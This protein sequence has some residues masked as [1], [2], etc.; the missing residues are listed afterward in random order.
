MEQNQTQ[1]RHLGISLWHI[2]QFRYRAVVTGHSWHSLVSYSWYTNFFLT[3]MSLE[4]LWNYH[5]R[6]HKTINAIK[7]HGPYGFHLACEFYC[8][9]LEETGFL[10]INVFMTSPCLS[11][12]FY[13]SCKYLLMLVYF[14]CS[15]FFPLF[16]NRS[17]FALPPL[18]FSS[19]N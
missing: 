3:C 5:T 9:V 7:W 4:V 8:S 2:F 14:A 19:P 16:W 18:F 10:W 6:Y 1:G 13:L 11:L 15:I 12:L 17:E